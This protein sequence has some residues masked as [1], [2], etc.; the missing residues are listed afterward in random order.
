MCADMSIGFKAPTLPFC[1]FWIFSPSETLG[2]IIPCRLRINLRTG[3]FR[4]RILLSVIPPHKSRLLQ[5]VSWKEKWNQVMLL[6]RS[7]LTQLHTVTPGWFDTWRTSGKRRI[8]PTN[9][10]WGTS[11]TF[12]HLCSS[13]SCNGHLCF[14]LSRNRK[15]MMMRKI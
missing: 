12:H 15:M 1:I 6:W 2:F 13:F 5:M 8:G 10:A 11:F 3:C 7:S 9:H 14:C 4:T